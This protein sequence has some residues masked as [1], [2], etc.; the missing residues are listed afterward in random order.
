MP[1]DREVQKRKGSRRC[2]PIAGNLLGMQQEDRL[3]MLLFT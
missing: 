3:Q 2:E 1:M